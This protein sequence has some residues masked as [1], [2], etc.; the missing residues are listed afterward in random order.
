M[1]GAFAGLLARNQLPRKYF[2]K[3]TKEAVRA[4]TTIIATLS[5]LVA[6]LLIAS[7]KSS[8]D[9]TETQIKQITANIVLIDQ[10]LEQYGPETKTARIDLRASMHALADRIWSRGNSRHDANSAFAI[11]PEAGKFLASFQALSP[12]TNSQRHLYGRVL[13]ALT[14]IG[15]L[16][17]MLF[18]QTRD[19]LAPPFVAILIF[20]LALVFASYTLFVRPDALLMAAIFLA[21]SACSAAIF[22]ILEMNDPLTG[23]MQISREPFDRVLYPLVE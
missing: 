7:T 8:Y 14:S 5:A 13:E 3:E 19:Q 1:A 17:L 6:G 15:Q 23:M 12:Q 22:L 11:T 18:A 2:R 4:A 20:W 9:A 21:A 16:R 10:I